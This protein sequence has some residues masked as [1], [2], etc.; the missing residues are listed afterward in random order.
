MDG[1]D[2]KPVIF[3]KKTP[4]EKKKQKVNS[5]RIS[6]GTKKIVENPDSFHVN[7]VTKKMGKQISSARLTTKLSQKELANKI[8]IPLKTL[9]EYEN[10]KATVNG[11]I[12]NKINRVLNIKIIRDD[13]K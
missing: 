2:W 5:I 6:Q 9:Q 12:I 11:N 8:N 4:L 10:G 1:Q 13:K 7:R 3:K